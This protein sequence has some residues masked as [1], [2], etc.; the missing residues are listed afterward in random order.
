RVNVLN[1]TTVQFVLKQ[2]F[3]P[4]ITNTLTQIPILPQHIFDGLM[5]K[6]GV[7][8]PSD[9]KLTPDLFVG[10]GPW[11]L[12]SFNYG[13]QVMF[14]RNPN[15]FIQPHFKNIRFVYFTSRSVAITALEQGQIDTIPS[16]DTLTTS[17]IQ[18]VNTYPSL[19]IAKIPT[20][21]VFDFHFNMRKFPSV[22][23]A[24][25][26]AV[27][28][29][30]NYDNIVNVVFGGDLIRGVGVIAPVSQAWVDTPLFAKEL[31]NIFSYNLTEAKRILNDAGYQWDIQG[32]LH[33]P[34]NLMAK[35]LAA[36]QTD[37]YKF[38]I[39][40]NQVISTVPTPQATSTLYT[41]Q[42]SQFEAFQPMTVSIQGEFD[43]PCFKA[44]D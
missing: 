39:A 6:Q 3:A 10:S 38:T 9:L 29:A 40:M 23:R 16:G 7:K 22:D 35:G 34:E 19:Q 30:I 27:A 41:A 15:Y 4:F 8:N 43:N 42:V 21:T 25:R 12:T 26:L 31:K 5:E 13:S 36:V 24:F 44:Y 11:K 18:E 2:P 20:G 33:Y 14:E 1:S 17:E 37:N 28:H 32:R